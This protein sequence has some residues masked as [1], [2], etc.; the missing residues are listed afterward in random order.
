MQVA[1]M[2]FYLVDRVRESTLIWA[3]LSYAT[4]QFRDTAHVYLVY[5]ILAILSLW[6]FRSLSHAVLQE[7]KLARLGSRAPSVRTWTPWNLSFVYDA[8]WYM[9]RHR[10]HE[11]WW[12]NFSNVSKGRQNAQWTAEAITLGDR[13]IFTADEENIKAILATQFKEYGKGPEFRK[14]WKDFLGLS[15]FCDC[16]GMTQL[17]GFHRHLHH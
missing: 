11:F 7:S 5:S 12:K 6:Y 13:L 1:N 2:L 9:R 16:C 3:G 14:E 8:V 15:R 4:W 17:M 10:N